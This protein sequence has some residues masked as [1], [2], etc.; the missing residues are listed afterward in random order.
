MEMM[1]DLSRRATTASGLHVFARTLRGMYET[2]HRATVKSLQ[3]LH[4]LLDPVL[5]AW[6]YTV[7]P[8]PLRE[9]I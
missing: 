2:G 9:L 8:K 4:L 6:N 3:Q 7:L 1:R 5:P